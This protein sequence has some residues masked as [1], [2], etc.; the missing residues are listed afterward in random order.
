MLIA[1]ESDARYGWSGIWIGDIYETSDENAPPF[2]PEV[3]SLS[4][5]CVSD[6][7]QTVTILAYAEEQLS[8]VELYSF[9][10]GIAQFST[11]MYDNGTHGDVT[12]WDNRYTT[13]IGPYPAPVELTMQVNLSDID[14]NSILLPIYPYVTNIVNIQNAGRLWTVYNDDGTIGDPYY[15]KPSM[16][17]YGESNNHYLYMGG[18]WVGGIV[19]G[20]PVVSASL[21]SNSD[22]WALT[23]LS[24]SSDISDNDLHIR[25][26]DQQASTS[27]GIEVDQKGLSW[28]SELNQDFIILEYTIYNT[29][30]HGNLDSVYFGLWSDFD[31]SNYPGAIDPHIDDTLS[32]DYSRNLIYMFDGDNPDSYENDTGEPDSSGHLQSPGYIGMSMLH[33][34]TGGVHLSWWNWETEPYG[35]DEFYQYL[36]DPTNLDNPDSVF[37][38][39]ALLS[40]GPFDIPAEDS[41]TI[42]IGYVIGNGLIDLLEN[43]DQMHLLY[44][45]GYALNLTDETNEIPNNFSLSQN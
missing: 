18:F 3:P 28:S 1:W 20:G 22:W 19:G 38:Y 42:V 14:G 10:S 6:S 44:D 33:T 9:E 11:Q 39:R 15:T 13:K 41:T 34:D 23:E 8:S 2:T 29:G 35:D 40:V 26:T 7:L 12:A 25:F 5:G 36:S 17:W 32:F 43:T 31:V 16:E 27:L 21:Y 37:D 30:L 4:P 24:S 45:N